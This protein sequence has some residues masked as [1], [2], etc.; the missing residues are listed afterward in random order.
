MIALRERLARDDWTFVRA[1]AAR[2][3]GAL[4]ADADTDR[5]LAAALADASPDVRAQTLDGL[6]AHHAVAHAD[7]VRARQDDDA[8]NVEVRAHAIL[9]L[10]TL[11]DARSLSA[12]TKL[13]LIARGPSDDKDRRLAASAIA[14]L[15]QLH[16]A[17]LE[18]RLAPLLAKDTPVA[19]REMARSALATRGE[20]GAGPR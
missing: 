13:A 3:L 1:G 5:A 15:G 18:A 2:T 12:W 10:A 17:D 19:A 14:A 11:C 4:P 16:P 9:A 8:E 6:G 20:C 7:A